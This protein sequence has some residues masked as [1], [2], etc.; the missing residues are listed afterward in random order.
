MSD[1]DAP[2]E[3]LSIDDVIS[4]YAGQRVVVKVTAWGEGR[5][6]SH[7]RVVAHGTE[8]DIR[9]ALRTLPRAESPDTP[10]YVFSAYPRIRSVE[11][12][13]AVLARAGEEGELRAWRRW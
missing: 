8:K 12:W 11:E 2:P 9:R 1:R 10:Y 5:I 4:R 3:S 6:P 7:G 13:R